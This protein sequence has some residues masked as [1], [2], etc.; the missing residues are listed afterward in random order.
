MLLFFPLC[1]AK[2]HSILLLSISK[3]L[4]QLAIYDT[5]FLFSL[6]GGKSP[7]YT[8]LLLPLRFQNLLRVIFF[9]WLLSKYSPCIDTEILPYLKDYYKNLFCG[10]SVGKA[11]GCLL[12]ARQTKFHFTKQQIFFPRRTILTPTG[13]S[14]YSLLNEIGALSLWLKGRGRSIHR[15]SPCGAKCPEY[16]E[17]RPLLT[18]L[19]QKPA[20]LWCGVLLSAI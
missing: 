12:G 2:I 6:H 14:H 16:V 15:L 4:Y 19:P 11:A 5:Q 17:L 18:I 7:F 10:G 13:T 20:P 3:S 9:C 1:V 8:P